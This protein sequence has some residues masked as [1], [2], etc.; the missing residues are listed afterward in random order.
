MRIIQFPASALF[1]PSIIPPAR[2][3]LYLDAKDASTITTVS[4]AVSR[5]RSKAGLYGFSLVQATAEK[6]PLLTQNALS[7]YPVVTT[8][9]VDDAM[10]LD[11]STI[12]RA[13][14]FQTQRVLPDGALGTSA[15]NGWT[16]TGLFYEPL[17]N[18]FWVSNDGR[19][20]TG[21]LYTP[22]IIKMNLAGTQILNQINI[23]AIYSDNTTVQGL[24]IDPQDS[25]IWFCALQENKI[26]NITQA[27]TAIKEYTFA[28]PNGLAHDN[29]NN[30][31]IVLNDFA[32]KMVSVINKSTGST[33]RSYDVSFRAPNGDQLFL[34]QTTRY[35]Y[36]TDGANGAAGTIQVYQHDNGAYIGS[37]GPFTQATAIE[38]IS[39]IG[40][41]IYILH[42]GYFHTEAIVRLNQLLTYSHTAL[43]T[44]LT[45]F[46][47]D[48]YINIFAFGRARIPAA[49]TSGWFYTGSTSP[50]NER[51]YGI[52][53]PSATPANNI[54]RIFVNGG[55]G[56]SARVTSDITVSGLGTTGYA[57]HTMII[58]QISKTCRYSLNG[59]TGTAF[60]T[61]GSTTLPAIEGFALGQ[62][63]L[64]A[65][66]SIS[67]TATIIIVTGQLTNAQISVIEGWLA[68]DWNQSTLLASGHTFKNTPPLLTDWS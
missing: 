27:G 62:G 40:N 20:T 66:Y 60:A 18:V 61:L 55:S 15:G 42:D 53:Q 8:D 26:R 65:R 24:A 34:D 2:I 25:S 51:G 64:S 16:C 37:I 5:W 39:I 32:P 45:G 68:W 57:L 7:G 14:T 21:S 67:N 52:Y 44:G 33:I 49:T 30:T 28:N 59:A 46:A 50:I 3:P 35:L 58:N 22:S 23:K 12:S 48:S 1:S 36:I 11:T 43:P 47:E 13:P 6:R 63:E 4:G 29:S 41:T 19:A 9:G 10:I 38:G 17:E 56:V 54:T 31:L